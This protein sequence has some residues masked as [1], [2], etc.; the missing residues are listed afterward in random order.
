M[1]LFTPGL[2]VNA[3]SLKHDP[4]MLFS[5]YVL[6]SSQHLQNSQVEL[7]N[8]FA[9]IHDADKIS[10]LFTLKLKQSP[11]NIDYQEKATA[12]IEQ[13]KQ[14]LHAMQV[15]SHWTGTLLFSNYGTQSAQKRF[16][17]LV[18]GRL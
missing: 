10:R 7:E 1:Q 15:T 14:Q 18:W 16:R 5:R 4:L 11:Y 13:S 6:A 8:G 2:P 9:T 3:E 12:W 17:P